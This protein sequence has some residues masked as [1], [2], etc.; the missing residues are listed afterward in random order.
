[1]KRL[2]S[3][4]GFLKKSKT[5]VIMTRIEE[6]ILERKKE[7]E[8]LEAERIQKQNRFYALRD[9]ITDKISGCYGADFVY[10]NR[11]YKIGY[12]STEVVYLVRYNQ[13]YVEWER[14]D[15]IDVKIEI[16][17]WLLE[18]RVS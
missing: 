9:R 7:V 1:M 13:T 5:G 12:S 17:A 8:K 15:D 6:M 4:L 14:V 10:N 3:S 16:F 11:K 2:R 18:E